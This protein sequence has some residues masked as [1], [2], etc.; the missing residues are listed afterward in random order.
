MDRS[1]LRMPDPDAQLPYGE[2][3]RTIRQKLH[4][5]VY[6]SF[7]TPQSGA[8]VD[9]SELL[10]LHEDGFSG[11]TAL[12][13]ALQNTAR[14]EVN[15]AVTLCL[16]LPETRQFVHGSGQVMWTDDTGRAGIRFS[17]LPDISRQ[18][19]KEWLFANLL[20][21]ST[22][23]SARTSQI[24]HQQEDLRADELVA[25]ERSTA[26]DPA[27]DD[28]TAEIPALEPERDLTPIQTPLLA[29]ASDAADSERA[30]LLSA[31][32]DVRRQIKVL[33]AGAIV[34]DIRVNSDAVLHFITERAAGFTGASGAALALLT[35]DKIICR[36]SVGEPAPPAGSEVDAQN[37]LSGEC[38]RKG[39]VVSCADTESDLRVD[40]EVCRMFGIGSFMAAPI[41]AEFRVIGLVEVFSPYPHTFAQ[42]H[43]IVLERLA[44]LVPKV[45]S[46]PANQK[47][48]EARAV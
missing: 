13:T 42:L 30:Q 2:R 22:N 44:E 14:L 19:L 8:V 3:R 36:A 17:F 9:L 27:S 29:N 46:E 20:V 28:S 15:R 12:P 31:L 32:D 48:M 43:G 45:E 38:L 18:V 11:Q 23:H 5:P 41:F 47:K 1:T 40:P 21:A 35:G 26:E 24:A 16:D 34:G 25:L 37:G 39:T 33:D 7:K 4:T 6:V 10:A